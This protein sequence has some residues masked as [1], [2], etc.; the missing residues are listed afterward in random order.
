MPTTN[1]R[2]HIIPLGSE[3]SFTREVLFTQFGLSIND[4]RP[5]ANATARDQFVTDM[6]AAG[7]EP[8][9]THPLFV[10]RADAPGLH[11]IEYTIDG[12]VWLPA[13]GRLQFSSLTAANSWA[14]AYPSLLTTG[15]AA[16]IA[17]KEYRWF[18][19]W[20]STDPT[21]DLVSGVARTPGGSLNV[22]VWSVPGT[23]ESVATSGWFTYN[24]ATGD[25]TVLNAGRYAV[26]ARLA[27]ASAAAYPDPA[28]PS[29]TKQPAIAVYIIRDGIETQI[30]TQDSVETHPTFSKMVKLSIPSISLAANTKLR[31]WI[32]GGGVLV[33]SGGTVGVGGVGRAN[34]EFM[35]RSL[36]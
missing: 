19:S 28:D 20:L 11:R 33:P 24:A 26:E 3:A 36:G 7:L 10:M 8:S 35:V 29:K 31:V 6:V 15:D 23:G 9:S 22:D 25:I 14:V 12:T 27:V 21:I 16:M 13:S 5:V 32:P 30:L 18:G 17:G 2:G 1:A 4:I 34:G